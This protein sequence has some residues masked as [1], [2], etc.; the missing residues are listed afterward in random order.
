M[1]I[2]VVI[3][4]EMAA[5]EVSSGFDAEPLNLIEPATVLMLA[6]EYVKFEYGA[7]DV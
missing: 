2:V 6:A 1:L 5:S 7:C 4:Q 3:V